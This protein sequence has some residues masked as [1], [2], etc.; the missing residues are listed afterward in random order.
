MGQLFINLLKT[1]RPRQWI[2]NL[3]L[4]AALVFSGRLFVV[5]DFILVT[6]AIIFF[7]GI[8]SSVYFL[9]DI[10]DISQDKIHPF[11]RLRPIASGRLPVPIAFYFA[12]TGLLVAF[13]LASRLSF[14]F[15]LV[16]FAYFVL[17]MT[18]SLL[19]KEIV[20]LDVLAIASGFILRIYAGAIILNY[21]V[22]SWF[23]LCVV[24]TAL[25]LAVGKRRAELAMLSG[26]STFAHRA[27]LNKYSETLLDSYL[28]IFA[29]SAWLSWALF[30]FFES[31]PV[32]IKPTIIYSILPL[33]ISGSNKF[34]MLTIP[35]VIYGIMRYLKITYEGAKAESP[36]RV[37]LY[38]RP[39]LSA[40]VVW[41]I[42]T[43]LIIYGVS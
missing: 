34:L 33:T 15:F 31:Q 4:Y 6:L 21:H 37:L 9:N 17:Q 41:G 43:V 24:S 27:T 22:S 13:S 19:L 14:F 11:K 16:C 28:A 35:V 20:I 1:A 12:V 40:V 3:T 38:D 8:T 7:S 42:I 18:Y 32:V 39:L 10:I 2:K 26:T 25:F 5:G 36:E 23:F 29:T 30:T